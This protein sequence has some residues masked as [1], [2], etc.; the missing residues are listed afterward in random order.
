MAEVSGLVELDEV[1][2]MGVARAASIL[3]AD[4]AVATFKSSRGWIIASG[5]PAEGISVRDRLSEG[6]P[7]TV[8]R[9][10][11]ETLLSDIDDDRWP[12]DTQNWARAKNLGPYVGVALKSSGRQ[13]G[14]LA[15]MRRKGRAPFTGQDLVLAQLVASSL[16]AA[17]H[18][19]ELFEDSRAAN[20]RLEAL[21]ASTESMWRPAPFLEAA[22][23]IVRSATEIVPGSQCLISMV[24]PERPSH[25]RIVAGSGS[26]AEHLVGREW[27][28]LGTVAGQAMSDDRTIET[29]GLQAESA[30]TETLAGGGIDTGRLIPLT[31]G[32]PL[33]AGRIALGVLG[34]YRAGS[35]PF[36]DAE[37]DLMDE[38]GKR[39]SLTLHRA[40]LQDAATRTNERL[41]TGL[42]LTLELASA[43]DYR[44][45][46]RRMLRRAVES[47]GADRA[48]LALVEDGHLVV[49]DGYDREGRPVSIGSRHE[50]LAGSPTEQA[51]R[52][53]RP[54]MS[55]GTE[56]MLEPEGR[57]AVPGIRHAAIIPLTLGDTVG[58]VLLLI[59]RSDLP[60][61]PDDLDLLQLIGNAAAVAL[62]N[63]ELYGEAYD[64][65]RTK[66]DFMNLA[67]H[68]LRTPLSVISGYLSMLRDGT[69][70]EP[71]PAWGGPLSVVSSKTEELGTLVED[72]LTAARLEAG[73]I[74][75][76]IRRMDLRAAVE[77][78]LLRSEPR[79]ALLGADLAAEV[80]TTPVEVEADPDHIGRII[81]NLVNNALTYST[82]PPW[83]RVAIAADPPS[84]TVSDRGVGIAGE[85]RDRVFERFYRIDHPQLPRQ[86]GTGLGLAISKELAE[87]LGG[88]LELLQSDDGATFR[89]T[90]PPPA[91]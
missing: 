9:E 46:I 12:E 69:F 41:E 75:T 19:A 17:I 77:A 32:R 22:G 57:E 59:R 85:L 6:T 26:W 53:G 88:S 55:E 58:A 24:P 48:G 65:S 18:V 47:V 56:A 43:L 89:L 35:A 68:E 50:I 36:N 45:V 61:A 67:A 91:V 14:V 49:E 90:L 13:H 78:S 70:G 4:L 83:V 16:A 31:T 5:D 3:D 81:D 84:I 33:P 86:P 74:P 11:G 76:A 29:T 38:F 30:L 80:P 21:L 1:L 2:V 39:V 44:E 51:I 62:R 54:R 63:A 40:E 64:L 15:V 82:G 66:S 27:P 37:R 71:P 73:T 8:V 34:F 60:Y 87:R 10:T 52:S 7:E 72:L 25:F 28:W 20:R 42:E 23:A 79:A